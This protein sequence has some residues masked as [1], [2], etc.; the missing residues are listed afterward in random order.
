MGATKLAL[1]DVW[2]LLLDAGSVI[3]DVVMISRSL[4]TMKELLYRTLV[5]QYSWIFVGLVEPPGEL[6]SRQLRT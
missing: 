2:Q 4:F 1:L 6:I 3:L 5:H